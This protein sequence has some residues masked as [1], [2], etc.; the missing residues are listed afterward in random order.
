[1]EIINAVENNP[2][3]FPDDFVF[4]LTVTEFKKLQGEELCLTDAGLRFEVQRLAFTTHGASMLLSIFA[5]DE[6]ALA[7]IPVFRAFTDFW[8]KTEPGHIQHA[9]KS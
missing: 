2:E 4:H 5:D 1:M 7:A 9:R 8:K 3:N 6:F